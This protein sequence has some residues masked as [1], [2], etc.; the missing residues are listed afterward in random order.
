LRVPDAI[1][2]EWRLPKTAIKAL[3]FIAN[4]DGSWAWLA[5]GGEDTVIYIIDRKSQDQDALRKQACEMTG[6]NLTWAEWRQSMPEGIPY[7]ATCENWPAHPSV[8]DALLTEGNQLARAGKLLEAEEKLGGA[9]ALDRNLNIEPKAEAKRIYVL[10]LLEVGRALAEQGDIAG[11]TAKFKEALALDPKLDIDL[12]AEAK[13]IFAVKVIELGRALAGQ[14]DIAGAMAKFKEALKY[15]P[16]IGDS[17]PAYVRG[18]CALNP[19]VIPAEIANVICAQFDVQI[20]PITSG[21]IVTETVESGAIDFW[22]FDAATAMTIT[23]DLKADNSNLDAYLYLYAADGSLLAENDDFS[24]TN[25][26]IEF[27]LPRAGRYY[28]G[29]AG[30]EDSKGAYRLQLMEGPPGLGT[31]AP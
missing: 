15:D 29:A 4:D 2:H 8:I 13:R 18:I 14:G 12:E 19:G 21:A 16:S 3:T 17:P 23:V 7:R 30:Y 22:S 20:S 10:K 24:D 28:V 25:A 11:A 27:T 26:R 1:L 31:P 6:R 5:A 9:L